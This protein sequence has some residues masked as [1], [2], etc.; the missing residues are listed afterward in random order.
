VEG[1][2]NTDGVGAID[3]IDPDSDGDGCPDGIEG[4]ATFTFSD[5]DASQML[6]GGVDN[7]GVPIIATASGQTLGD[8]QNAGVQSSACGL[9]PVIISQVYQT[10][11]GI[12]I[13]L[14]NIGA[15]TVSNIRL[16]LFK[17]IGSSSP[18][19]VSPT[20]SQTVT[21]LASGNSIIIK[22]V[23]TLPGVIIINSPTEILNTSI[24]DLAGGDDTIVL[25]STTDNTAWANRYDVLSSI[26]DENAMVRIDETTMANTTFTASEWIDFVDDSIEV[27]GD[28]DPI[29]SSIRHANDP[30][31]SEV[32]T[33]NSEA[34]CGL[35]LH[36]INPTI[37][38]SALW[39]NG[40]PDKSRSVII[41]ENYTHSSNNLDARKLDVQ[42]TSKL[43]IDDFGLIVINNVNIDADAEIRILGTG[44][45]IQVHDGQT[46]V[47][48]TGK[49]LI[50][51]KSEIPNVYRYNYWSSPVVEEK[52]GNK[53]RVSEIMKDASGDLTSTSTLEDIDFV[54]GFDGASTSPIEI[55]GYWIWTYFNNTTRDSWVQVEETGFLD[56]GLGY[57]M[58]STGANPQYFT[59]SGSPIDG[60]ISFN[61]SGETS[62]LLGNPYAGTLDSRAFILNNEDAIDGTLYFWEHSGEDG[63]QGH[64]K[65]GYEGGY[66]QL[67]FAMGTA[68][69]T[70]IDGI[71]GL[72]DMYTYK[73]PSRYIAQGQ[74]FFVSSDI[75]GG[76]VNFNNKQRSFQSTEPDFFKSGKVNS[77]KSQS[78]PKLKLGM[79]YRNEDGLIIHRQIG[80]SFKT[81]NTFGFDYG[82]EAEMI[83]IGATDI[84]FNF[85][86]MLDKKLVIAGVN[87]I[88]DNLN[89]PLSIIVDKDKELAL[90]IDEL[91]NTDK[92]I[93]LYDA[94]KGT[95]SLLSQDN[96]ITL[97]LAKGTYN[98]RFFIV[99]NK[100]FTLSLNTENV[101]KGIDVFTKN[102]NRIHI[103]NQEGFYIDEVEVYSILGQ[104]IKSWNP[105]S[106]QSSM[107]F[108]SG[109][110][111]TSIY[112]I[113]VSTEK[114]VFTK[115]VIL[116]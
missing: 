55:S 69:N 37:R 57:I 63:D 7:N 111:P 25:S 41:Q 76:T 26:T 105:K 51:Q 68:A 104:Q 66:A 43:N 48:G 31:L 74:A 35:G 61:L 40:Y 39:S 99:F 1:N 87:A 36:R 2:G 92:E 28:S 4:G 11:T 88:S 45:F 96:T 115:K 42:G 38:T 93:Y 53:Y 60:D 23:A 3:S 47:S 71:E 58:K 33:P 13:E 102:N 22:S 70:A 64:N 106:Y 81:G 89:V 8:S 98:E 78:F 112:I 5:L 97:N 107:E 27:L 108:V 77:K 34:N 82:F 50:S 114:G 113:K 18:D 12:A 65:F 100:N 83:D 90:R 54:S 80:V 15:T 84:Y 59:F 79:N 30:L 62:T 24:T 16:S 95:T 75:D 17:D 86:E 6:L 52:G 21:T 94:V 49:L 46:D 85:K 20:A 110:I 109:K 72:T 73:T 10:S 101:I 9:L 14:T 19:G 91:E 32:I 116:E 67:T 29:P 56:K 103:N 44:Q